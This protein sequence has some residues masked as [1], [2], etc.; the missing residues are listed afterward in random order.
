M[1]DVL[2][3]LMWNL[4]NDVNMLSLRWESLN[5][6]PAKSF[7]YDII[8]CQIYFDVNFDYKSVWS[9]DKG[10][11]QVGPVCEVFVFRSQMNP[12]VGSRTWFIKYK[13]FIGQDP[14]SLC[15]NRE[16]LTNG[17]A[18]SSCRV[19]FRESS[20]SHKMW[21]PLSPSMHSWVDGEKWYL[22]CV[23]PGM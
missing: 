20:N 12:Y 4:I 6:V 21:T 9:M 14:S 11:R 17:F 19:W 2:L 22:S 5:F 10:V 13:C 18:F 23:W 3:N 15:I 1:S 16:D 7:S 8:R